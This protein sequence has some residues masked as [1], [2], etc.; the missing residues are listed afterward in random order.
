MST[1]S[2]WNQNLLARY[3]HLPMAEE[4]QQFLQHKLDEGS[5]WSSLRQLG[6]Y[7]AAAVSRMQLTSESRLT[8]KAI[9]IAAKAWANREPHASRLTYPQQVQNSKCAAFGSMSNQ[10]RNVGFP[11]VRSK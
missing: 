5:S 10:C 6:I 9:D 4:R 8:P 2:L 7:I 1:E 11:P 3:A